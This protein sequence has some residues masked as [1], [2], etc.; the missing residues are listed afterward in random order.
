MITTDATIAT[1]LLNKF[2]GG[3][4]TLRERSLTKNRVTL[5]TTTGAATDTVLSAVVTRYNQNEI[6]GTLILATDLK[7]ISDA[8]TTISKS[9]ADLIM[10][11]GEAHRIVSIR[12]IDPAGTVLAYVIQ[13]RL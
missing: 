7:I 5:A 6:D 11:G 13:A 3:S 9:D 8:V 1:R 4:V 10:V 12:K 2:S